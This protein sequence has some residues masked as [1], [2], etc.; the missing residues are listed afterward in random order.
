MLYET[1][2]SLELSLWMDANSIERLRAIYLGDWRK[3]QD[4]WLE[5]VINSDTPADKL[6]TGAKPA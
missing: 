2:D 1:V 4:C 3:M 6:D 5:I